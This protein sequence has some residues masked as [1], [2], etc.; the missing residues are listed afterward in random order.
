MLLVLIRLQAP[1]AFRTALDIT[2]SFEPADTCARVGIG[3]TWRWAGWR[4][5]LFDFSHRQHHASQGRGP[6][7]FI[8]RDAARRVVY[9]WHSRR[10]LVFGLMSLST[11]L[12]QVMFGRPNRVLSGAVLVLGLVA[13]VLAVM[14]QLQG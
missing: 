2:R 9:L 1:I 13:V 4:H 3:R 8:H 12:S 6:C 11:G 10:V 7:E 5:G 14:F